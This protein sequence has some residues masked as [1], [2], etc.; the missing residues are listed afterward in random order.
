MNFRRA[1]KEGE[2]KGVNSKTGKLVRTTTVIRERK[3]EHMNLNNDIEVGNRIP[4]PFPTTT[5]TF[6]RG[7]SCS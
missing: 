5:D 4:L 7:L 1:D 3:D 6:S 2:S